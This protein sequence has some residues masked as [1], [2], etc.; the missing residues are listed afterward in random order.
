MDYFR[1]I[2]S[3]AQEAEPI[4]KVFH[5]AAEAAL[6]HNMLR[7]VCGRYGVVEVWGK[8]GRK[9]SLNRLEALARQ[10]QVAAE[11]PTGA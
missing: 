4:E 7:R 1:I 6:Q 2:G 9:I 8:N 10:E 5:T 11:P 3:G